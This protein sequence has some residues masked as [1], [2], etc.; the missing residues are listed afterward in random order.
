MTLPPLM[1]MTLATRR[2]YADA[3]LRARE[4]CMLV[5]AATTAVTD[6]RERRRQARPGGRDAE[7]AR[8]EREIDARI[9]QEEHDLLASIDR[10]LTVL[11]VRPEAFGRCEECGRPIDEA[12]LDVAPWLAR[13]AAHAPGG[14]VLNSLNRRST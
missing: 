12:D 1:S 9:A 5:V 3:L 13:C 11:R 4:E 2:R 10:A 6:R 8:L 7:G 14:A